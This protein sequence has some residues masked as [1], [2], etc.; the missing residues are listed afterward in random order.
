MRPLAVPLLALAVVATAGCSAWRRENHLRDRA[1]QHVYQQPL[2]AVWPQAMQLIREEGYTGKEVPGAFLYQ[3]EWKEELAGAVTHYTRYLVEGRPAQGAGCTVHFIKVTRSSGG[4]APGG[5]RQAED[6]NL[7]SARSPGSQA[8][9]AGS[10]QNKAAPL[11]AG[12]TPPRGGSR[13]LMME[14][15]LLQRVDPERAGAIEA[16]ADGKPKPAPKQAAPPTL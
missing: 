3:S 2:E 7:E 11:S 13:D 6:I 5:A 16:E 10:E 15:R 1:G 12:A 8:G 14:W 4:G 9:M